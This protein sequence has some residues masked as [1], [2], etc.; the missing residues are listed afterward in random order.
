MDKLL[1]VALGSAIGGVARYLVGRFLPLQSDF[2]WPTFLVNVAG[3]FLIGLIYG[4]IDR[5]V[6]MS[7]SARLF[8]T[9]GFCGGFT[10]FSTFVHENYVLFGSGNILV[11]AAYA[12]LS[13]FVGIILAYAGHA[14]ARL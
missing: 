8:L 13:F 5:G 10:T 14:L 12:A 9:V 3:C 11:V 4:L 2:P 1:F 6:G 7:E